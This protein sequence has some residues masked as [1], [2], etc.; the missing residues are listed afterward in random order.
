MKT[1]ATANLIWMTTLALLV[2]ACA[3]AR[4][5]RVAVLPLNQ[6]AGSQSTGAQVGLEVAR[7][8]AVRLAENKAL[9]VIPPEELPKPSSEQST[10]RISEAREL[11]R[12]IG[13]DFV[14]AGTID[15]FK[16]SDSNHRNK[17]VALAVAR[18]AVRYSGVP[19][20]SPAVNALRG[21]TGGSRVIGRVHV[22]LDLKLVDVET[23]NTIS[24]IKTKGKS[25]KSTSD[26]LDG[27]QSPD[28]T[29]DTFAKTAAGEAVAAAVSSSVSSIDAVSDKL[30]KH[31]QHRPLGRISDISGDLI[32]IDAG[33]NRGL[34]KATV[35]T[36]VSKT[37]DNRALIE[38]TDVGDRTSLGR[39]KSGSK[40][41]IGDVIRLEPENGSE[42]PR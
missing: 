27:L 23:G 18:Q 17:Q 8:I 7:L 15:E 20:A 29:S 12:A 38:V 6:A 36:A 3:P 37:A 32:S 9:E 19:Y 2:M 33:K 39:L 26:I 25:R 13:A 42:L 22:A 21:I 34:K 11:A 28:F 24:H 40:P 14:I 5:Q 4:A 1:L 30:S 41:E 16:I 10:D 31:T 35:L